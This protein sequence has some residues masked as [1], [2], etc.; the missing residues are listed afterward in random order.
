LSSSTPQCNQFAFY[1]PKSLKPRAPANSGHGAAVT[2]SNS[3]RPSLFP[4]SNLISAVQSWFDGPNQEIPLRPHLLQKSPLVFKESTRSPLR[5]SRIR[6]LT[7]KAY[8][9]P[10]RFKI[11]FLKI[12]DLPL[13]LFYS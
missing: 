12:T 2:P 11:H 4:N 6:F 9:R 13:I 3:G 10:L 8:S 1:R 7:P 5:I